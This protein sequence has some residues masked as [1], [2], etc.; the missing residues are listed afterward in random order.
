M[1][2]RAS[3]T[4]KRGKASRE[5]HMVISVDDFGTGYSSMDY[6][7]RLPVKC[8]RGRCPRRSSRRG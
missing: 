8:S 5:P 6:L 1:R 7:K 2:Q 4:A 3:G